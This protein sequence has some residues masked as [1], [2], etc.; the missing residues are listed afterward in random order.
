MEPTTPQV[1]IPKPAIAPAPVSKWLNRGGYSDDIE[2]KFL[3]ILAYGEPGS[4]KTNLLATFP[5]CFVVDADDGLL[6]ASTEHIFGMRLKRG[7]ETFKL[8]IELLTDIKL[9]RNGF[10]PTGPFGTTKSLGFDSL[11]KLADILKQDIMMHPVTGSGKNGSTPAAKDSTDGKAEWDQYNLL[12]ERLTRIVD[13]AREL[14]LHLIATAWVD[15]DYDKEGKP[16]KGVPNIV[17]GY[18]K[19]VGGNFD[20]MFFMEDRGGQDITKRYVL[21]TEPYGMYPSK[22]RLKLPGII[23]NPSFALLQEALKKGSK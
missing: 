18:K 4:G 6:T 17:G 11:S 12:K 16:I 13:L 8:L 22:T 10:E 5:N 23:Y 7:E 20:G 15:Y 14:P 9:K 2:T 19:T 1:Q 3:R 21:R